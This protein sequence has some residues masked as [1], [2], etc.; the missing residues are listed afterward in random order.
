MELRQIPGKDKDAFYD[1]GRGAVG[2]VDTLDK[3][4]PVRQRTRE[5]LP[6]F[7]AHRLT[8]ECTLPQRAE[9]RGGFGADHLGELPPDDRLRWLAGNGCKFLI[10]VQEPKPSVQKRD[11]R[12]N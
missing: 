8:G 9:A 3:A 11:P 5:G 2:K 6:A 1:P 7:P 4:R 12:R 10:D